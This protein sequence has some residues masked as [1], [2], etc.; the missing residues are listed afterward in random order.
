MSK[1]EN[2]KH[3]VYFFDDGWTYKEYEKCELDNKLSE[4][5][6]EKYE[7]MTWLD[8]FKQEIPL[9]VLL[10]VVSGICILI[11]FLK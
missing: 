9:L 5:G 4:N 2:C 7:E 8:S 3:Y 10:A 6:C 1:C 11:S